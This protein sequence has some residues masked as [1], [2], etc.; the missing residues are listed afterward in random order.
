[1]ATKANKNDLVVR[2]VEVK[3][4]MIKT[5]QSLI[6]IQH[7]ISLL[8]YK[9]W[10]LL[11]RE[12]KRQFDHGIPPDETGLRSISMAAI[13][14]ALK[15]RPNKTD[16][17]KDMLGLKNETI[18][19]NI[20]EK[21]GEK[22]QYGS[23]FVSEWKIHSSR[24]EF[25]LPSFIEEVVR[26][27][28]APKAIFQQL[29]WDI[30]NHFSG[31]YEA[32]IYKMCRDYRGVGR[33]PYFLLADFRAYMGLEDG[34]YKE[35]RDLNKFVIST[36]VATITSSM[37]SDIIVSV[38]LTRHGRKVIGL[39]FLIEN[40]M[41]T[42]IPFDDEVLSSAFVE[43]KTVIE[44]A[45]RNKYLDIRSEE[46]IAL[47][48]ERANEYGQQQE[49]KGGEPNY[50]ALY[51]TAITEGWHTQKREKKEKAEKI[52][53]AL[54]QAQRILLEQEDAD[55]ARNKKLAEDVAETL[56]EFGRLQEDEQDEIREEF[57][58][59]LPIPLRKSFDRQGETA[60]II[61]A[62]FA[63]FFRE[64]V[65]KNSVFSSKKKA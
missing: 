41:Q 35:F 39:R 34:E 53:I 27:M 13:V 9:Y 8:Q 3:N 49:K 22:I 14:A 18:V 58:A 47:C 10:I 52:V 32:I 16:I 25:K 55:A 45:T 15:Y 24:I 7:K 60:S 61:K 48:I 57:R 1:M 31:K 64:H 33:T 20:L 63:T 36:P 38:E 51:R 6:H 65:L 30:F 17:F 56:A 62:T 42:V 21:D 2:K 54:E 5:P 43:A 29:N 44:L 50:G 11:L 12:L 40:K 4:E 59:T 19:Y 26:G 28:D 23:G 46:E 37:A